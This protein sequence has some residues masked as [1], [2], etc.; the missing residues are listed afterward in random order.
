VAISII[1]LGC[2]EV[3]KVDLHICNWWCWIHLSQRSQKAVLSRWERTVH[4]TNPCLMR[5]TSRHYNDSCFVWR[6]LVNRSI[7]V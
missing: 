4:R 6:G 7:R 3:D 5:K 1:V 2:S